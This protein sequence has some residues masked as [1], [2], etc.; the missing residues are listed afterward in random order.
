MI[1]HAL[2]HFLSRM[3]GQTVHEQ[4]LSG[5]YT[6]HVT[7]NLPIGEVAHALFVFG[8]EAHRGPYVGRDQIGT[9]EDVTG[10]RSDTIM[11][12][13]REKGG[14]AS[15]AVDWIPAGCDPTTCEGVTVSVTNLNYQWISPIA[16]IA[17][18]S[19]AG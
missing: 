5:R 13:R 19:P 6:H 18:K 2:R 3:S 4:G 17:R 9:A 10:S 16:G 11:I 15:L 7:I 8:F 1:E 14:G 12:L